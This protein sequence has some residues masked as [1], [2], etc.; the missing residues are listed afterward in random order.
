MRITCAALVA[1]GLYTPALAQTKQEPPAVPVGVVTAEK[2]PVPKA[3]DF[4]GRV[5]A[6]NRVEVRARVTGYLEGVLFKEG[7]LVQTAKINLGYTAITSPVAGK[8]GKTNI[9]K[10]NVVGPESGPLTVV[11]SQDPMYVSFPVSQREFLR[12]QQ[13]QHKSDITDIKVQ[14]R[15][16]DGSSYKPT[17]DADRGERP[18]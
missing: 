11:V 5:E 7:D 1:C 4:V 10:G 18:I 9:T 8:I 3:L 14:L 12:A 16:A 17:G 13:D 15:F 6:V 2:K